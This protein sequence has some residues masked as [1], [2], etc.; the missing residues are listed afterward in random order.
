MPEADFDEAAWRER[1]VEYR[2]EKDAYFA[3]DTDA[4]IP[5]ADREGFDG[6]SYY[7]SDP[8][9]RRVARLQWAQR[10]EP[11]ALPANRGPDIEYE[12]VATLGFRLDGDHHVLAGFRAP[13]TTDLVVPFTD[14][15]NG[16]ETAS[17]GRY[18]SLAVDDVETGADVVLDFNLAYH[19]FCVYDDEYVSVLAPDENDLGVAVRAGE[20]L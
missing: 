7:L 20:R 9:F 17:E 15:T 13:G 5:D 11:I 10:P 4:P 19:P 6:L 14:E 16:A 8:S 12:R 18:V 3:D 2:R 1:V